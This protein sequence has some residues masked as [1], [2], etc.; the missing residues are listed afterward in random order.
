MRWIE[1][2]NTF[3]YFNSQT[4]KN[5]FRSLSDMNSFV[6]FLKGILMG[7]CDL[8]PGISGGTIALITGIYE[9]LITGMKNLNI[10]WIYYLLHFIF[11]GRTS[12]WHKARLAFFDIDWPFFVPLGT[13]ILLAIILGAHLITYLLD[14]AFAYTMLF[15]I[16]LILASIVLIQKQITSKLYSES[17]FLLVGG[18]VGL[19]FALFSPTSTP[20]AW[21][22]IIFSGFIAVFALFLPGVSGSY[23]LLLLDKYEF[24]LEA[25]KQPFSHIWILVLFVI[26]AIIGMYSI[27]HAISYVLKK[28]HDATLY[29]LI[30]VVMG[31]LLLPIMDVLQTGP[32]TGAQA[33]VSLVFLLIGFGIPLTIRYFVSRKT[34]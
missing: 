3:S 17:K 29:G 33:I 10:R 8:V 6:L 34:L 7:I 28:A 24:I 4:F 5:R 11:T 26:G 27:S 9:R 22:F 2:S 23:L 14:N 13:G 12:S 18:I 30:G 16:G 15:F 31:S 1:Q 25:V 32:F 19:L 21:W 20:T